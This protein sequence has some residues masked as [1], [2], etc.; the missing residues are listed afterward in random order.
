MAST[1]GG[2]PADSSLPQFS[3]EKFVNVDIEKLF[4]IVTD[5]ECLPKIIPK[6]FPSVRILSSRDNISVVEEHRVLADRELVMMTK[7]VV[8]RPY[9]HEFFVIGGD[10][11]GSHIRE[12]FSRVVGGTKIVVDADLKFRGMLQAMWYFHRRNIVVE[13]ED[14]LDKFAI[15]AER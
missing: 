3:F 1:I 4:D 14:I 2:G 12:R 11:K 13:Y 9:M 7:H 8:T 10:A 5:F 15:L 6:H